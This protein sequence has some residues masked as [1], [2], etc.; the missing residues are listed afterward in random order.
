MTKKQIYRIRREDGGITIT[1]KRPEEP[2]YEVAG[3]RLIADDGK[4]LTKDGI[5]F[6]SVKDVESDEG[7][8]E[9][10]IQIEESEEAE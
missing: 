4:A 1:P 6:Y 7:Y 2:G 3:V 8:Y 10:D 9:V 5:E